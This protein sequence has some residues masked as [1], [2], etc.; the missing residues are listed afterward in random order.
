[1]IELVD[2]T[3]RY[4]DTTVVD[5]LN[6]QIETGEIVGIKPGSDSAG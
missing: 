3:K 1:M 2:I 4:N 6:L 5:N